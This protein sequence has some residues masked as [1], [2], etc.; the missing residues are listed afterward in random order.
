MYLQQVF[1]QNFRCLRELTASFTPGL[2][3]LAGENN[4]GK[5]AF[6]DAIRAALGPASTT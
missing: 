4:V 2:N 3:V 1:I 5:T 6:L